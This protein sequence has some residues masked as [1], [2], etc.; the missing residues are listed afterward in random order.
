MLLNQLFN[1]E[2]LMVK[3]S[4]LMNLL[5]NGLVRMKSKR[6]K[7]KER[8]LLKLLRKQKRK[9]PKKKQKKLQEVVIKLL[10][11]KLLLMMKILIHPNTLRLEESG[12]N[13]KEM[14]EETHIHTNSIE[15]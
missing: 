8:R 5:G 10:K 13:L 3:K 11:R 14:L 2:K 6:D 4:S 7:H 1:Q 15:I 12:F 9:K